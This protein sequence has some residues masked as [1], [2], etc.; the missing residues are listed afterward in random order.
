MNISL[1]PTI[2]RV[3]RFGLV[4]VTA[5]ITHAVILWILV[6]G[7]FLPATQATVVGFL[8]A[9]FVSYFGH[10]YLTFQ[11]N[12]AHQRALPRFAL[13]AGVGAGLNWMVFFV[14]VDIFAWYYWFA[15]MIVI[16]TVPFVVYFMSKHLAFDPGS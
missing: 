9:F 4:G 14:A 16:F 5:T 1:A 10:F 2:F 6:E 15:F 13:T 8:I 3:I 7:Y 12:Q 11:S